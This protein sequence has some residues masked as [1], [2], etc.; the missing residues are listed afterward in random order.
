[1]F[2]FIYGSEEVFVVKILLKKHP[3]ILLFFAFD[4]KENKFKKE[5][6]DAKRRVDRR[7]ELPST[8]IWD[9]GTKS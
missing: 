6:G 4:Q 1:M 7:K 3:N 9:N 8:V 2:F 5:G